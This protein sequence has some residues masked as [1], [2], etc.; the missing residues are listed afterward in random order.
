MFSAFYIN[1]KD[2]IVGRNIHQLRCDNNLN[3]KAFGERLGY[4]QRTISDWENGNTEPDIDA[5]RKIVALFNVSYE[6]LLN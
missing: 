3:Q 4:S 5:I 2:N 6:E 1:M